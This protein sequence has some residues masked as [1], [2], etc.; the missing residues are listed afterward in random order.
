[1][2]AGRR[3]RSETTMKALDTL[4]AAAAKDYAGGSEYGTPPMMGWAAGVYLWIKNLLRNANTNREDA[5]V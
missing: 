1:M 3:K 4:L 2:R 5:Y